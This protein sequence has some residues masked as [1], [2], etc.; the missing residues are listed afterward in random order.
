M[1]NLFYLNET[2]LNNT[3]V[4]NKKAAI[5]RGFFINLPNCSAREATAVDLN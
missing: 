5:S 4:S 2:A 3:D 1:A